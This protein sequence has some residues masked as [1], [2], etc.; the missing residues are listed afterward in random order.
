MWGYLNTTE[1]C[2]WHGGFNHLNLGFKAE[3]ITYNLP[4]R[5]QVWP[6]GLAIKHV[7]C[8][9]DVDQDVQLFNNKFWCYLAVLTWF[10][11]DLV[12]FNRAFIGILQGRYDP[13]YEIWGCLNQQIQRA[14]KPN[15]IC[16]PSRGKLDTGICY[17]IQFGYVWT[18]G[19]L[20]PIETALATKFT[21]INQW[22]GIPYLQFL[23][24][25]G[26]GEP[27]IPGTCALAATRTS[28]TC[29]LHGQCICLQPRQLERL[30][31]QRWPT[32]TT[33]CTQHIRVCV[34][35]Q[36]RHRVFRGQ[37]CE[38]Q[39]VLVGFRHSG[40]EPASEAAWLRPTRCQ[41][42]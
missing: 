37:I 15:K 28:G 18:S 4:S 22:N 32:L 7:E 31:E 26:Q 35:F 12:G 17:L 3:S 23:W 42:I 20:K 19:G 30:G 36:M 10:Q 14:L 8:E 33:P 1:L 41:L 38:Q 40:P 24:H 13:L 5:G 9:W 34:F 25:C 2:V 6:L 11:Q 39:P 21:G 29:S 27:N 16:G